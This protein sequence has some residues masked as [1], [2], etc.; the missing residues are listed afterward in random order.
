M[1]SDAAITVIIPTYKPSH[2]LELAIKSVLSQKLNEAL[3]AIV[4]VDDHSPAEYQEFLDDLAARYPI[5][6]VRRKRNGGPA[7]AHNTGISLYTADFIAFLEHD[8]IWHPGKLEKQMTAFEQHPEWGACYVGAVTINAEGEETGVVELTY[9][10]GDA[11]LPRLLQG[12]CIYSISSMVLRR[13]CI[14]DVGAF[15]ASF[16]VSLDYDLWLRIAASQRWQIGCVPEPL[17]R[18]RIHDANFSGSRQEQIVEEMWRAL[19]KCLKIR[20]DCWPLAAR[21][22]AKRCLTLAQLATKKARFIEAMQWNIRGARA[23]RKLPYNFLRWAASHLYQCCIRIF[24]T[25]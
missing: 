18:Y 5:H 15:D 9:V 14:E 6:L 17:L 16:W 19:D 22:Y 23:D 2:F 4:V 3:T 13:A 7:A 11:A 20:P 21:Q 25:S 12:N 24:F 1:L 10:S 8:D